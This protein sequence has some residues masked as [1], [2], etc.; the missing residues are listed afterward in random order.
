MSETSSDKVTIG[1][2]TIYGIIASVIIIAVV[3]ICFFRPF[4]TNSVRISRFTKEEGSFVG[5]YMQ[6]PFTVEVEN[7][8]SNDVSGL[9]LVVKVLADYSEVDRDIEHL[10][11]LRAGHKV[12]IGMYCLVDYDLLQGKVSYVATLQLDHTILD[13]I[14]LP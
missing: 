3:L 7:L 10:S 14:T 2:K 5:N 4:S 6:F 1:K 8:G 9:V 11:T 13:E 12:T